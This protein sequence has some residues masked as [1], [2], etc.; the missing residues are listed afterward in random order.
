MNLR[1]DDWLAVQACG[2]GD[3]DGEGAGAEEDAIGLTDIHFDG[4][5]A[6]DDDGNAVGA[7]DMR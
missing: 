1:F 5:D 3:D 2:G 7:V 6:A 4:G